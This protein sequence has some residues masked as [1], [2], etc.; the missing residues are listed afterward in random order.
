MST[1]EHRPATSPSTPPRLTPLPLPTTQAEPA[2][3]G[4]HAVVAP[5]VRQG[6]PHRA[7]AGEL[8]ALAFAVPISI[9]AQR[10]PSE[11]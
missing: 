3:T 6:R 11:I 7:Q 2:F 9:P 4:R 5:R 8:A 1:T 10:G